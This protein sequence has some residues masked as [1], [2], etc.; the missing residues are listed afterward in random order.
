MG[1]VVR[2]VEL[3]GTA[4]VEAFQQVGIAILKIFAAVNQQVILFAAKIP[5][6]ILQAA[7]N[8]MTGGTLVAF[9]EDA[10]S[11]AM[12][13][14]IRGISNVGRSSVEAFKG[15]RF[16]GTAKELS[17]VSEDIQD[18]LNQIAFRRIRRKPFDPSPSV[19]GVAGGAAPETGGGLKRKTIDISTRRLSVDRFLPVGRQG[20]SEFA[21][22]IQDNLLKMQETEA[23]EILVR[24]A[25]ESAKREGKMVDIAEEEHEI[26]KKMLETMKRLENLGAR[27]STGVGV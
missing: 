14:A 27:V 12:N 4:I 17:K 22:A 15:I 16:E 7:A 8:R 19:P 11:G 1:I 18:I 20:F 2:S 21:S 26:S 24:E 9:V 23:D 10:M 3:A 25:L 6:L 13:E 5:E